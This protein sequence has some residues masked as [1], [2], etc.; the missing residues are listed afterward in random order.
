MYVY[1]GHVHLI[2]QIKTDLSVSSDHVSLLNNPW[3]IS[4]II[5]YFIVAWIL[6]TAWSLILGNTVIYFL[7]LFLECPGV[8]RAAVL[9]PLPA[10]CSLFSWET[11]LE[12]SLGRWKW[13]IIKAL[14]TNSVQNFKNATTEIQPRDSSCTLNSHLTEWTPLWSNLAS[15][16][17]GKQNWRWSD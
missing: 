16:F 6:V 17:W 10:P 14:Y 4:Q 11:F 7:P 9:T 12:I 3:K 5:N 1:S 15:A 13:V 8:C 2:L